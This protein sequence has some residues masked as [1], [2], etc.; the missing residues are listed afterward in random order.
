M[1]FSAADVIQQLSG[2]SFVRIIA[3]KDGS[4]LGMLC[5]RH[6]SAKVPESSLV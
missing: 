4:R 1:K 6:G 3:T 5:I 2:P